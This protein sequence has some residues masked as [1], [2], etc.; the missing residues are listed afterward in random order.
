MYFLSNISFWKT[1]EVQIRRC[2]PILESGLL[3]GNETLRSN[4]WKTV[5]DIW[6]T[7]AEK[8]GDRIAL[9]DPYHNPATNMTYRQASF[10]IWQLHFA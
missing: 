10:T 4:E 1:K 9:V 3:S 5:P 8:F 2:S 7:S 6:R